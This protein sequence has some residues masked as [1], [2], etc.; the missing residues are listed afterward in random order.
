VSSVVARAGRPPLGRAEAGSGEQWSAAAS[1]AAESATSERDASWEAQ[2]AKL[3]AYKRRH[4]DCNVPARWAEDPRLGSWVRRQ[5][6]H[7]KNLHHGEPSGRAT[8]ARV[9][10]LDSLGFAWELSAAELRKQRSEANR[11]HAGWA[12]QLAK[13]KAY[14]RRHGDCNV[15]QGWTEDPRLGGWVKNQRQ[16]KKALDRGEPSEGMTAVRVAKLEALGFA[17]E[18]SAAVISKQ[19]SKG[20]RDDAGWE[21][22]LAKLDA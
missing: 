20:H 4:G 1:A 11:D 17:W 14:K 2:L 9:A 8:V 5:R 19:H 10:K 3:K 18:V 13:L 22:Q 16:Y 12:A 7:K 6:N 21:V 15:P